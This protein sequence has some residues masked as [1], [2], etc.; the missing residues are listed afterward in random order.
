GGSAS[1][2]RNLAEVGDVRLAIASF[3]EDPDDES[4]LRLRPGGRI[5]LARGHSEIMP[6]YA[7]SVTGL[8]ER[9]AARTLE[10]VDIPSESG[11]E[12]EIREHLL[13]LVAPTLTPEYAD[14]EAFLFVPE[15]RPGSPL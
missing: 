9:L 10:L 5:G 2:R 13:G 4:A 15:R 11:S 14:D 1:R 12:A 6:R 3:R 8:A 7:A